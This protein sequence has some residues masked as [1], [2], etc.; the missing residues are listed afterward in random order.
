[1]TKAEESIYPADDVLPLFL[2]KEEPV[3]PVQ[4]V[5]TGFVVAS[6][7]LVTCAHV[8]PKPPASSFYAAWRA[9]R[10]RGDVKAIPLRRV[11][12]NA[13]APDLAVAEIDLD[14]SWPF[15]LNTELLEWGEEVFCFGYPLTQRTPTLDSSTKF[16]VQARML[17]G[18]VSRRLVYPHPSFGPIESYELDMAVPEGLSGAPVLRRGQGIVGVAYGS[19]DVRRIEEVSR[20]DPDTGEKTPELQR[21][22]SF[23]LAHHARS[24]AALL[25]AYRANA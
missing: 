22:V 20:V 18:Y 14:P 9:G 11:Y 15:E 10:A 4:F 24:V 16:D 25:A 8:V 1:M 17:R 21:V 2:M 23:G 3:E 6:G 12:V 7:L 5:G 13:V 19:V